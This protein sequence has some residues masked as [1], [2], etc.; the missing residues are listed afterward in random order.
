V[1]RPESEQIDQASFECSHS[2]ADV[3]RFRG[4]RRHPAIVPRELEGRCDPAAGSSC[5][6]LRKRER[7]D[8]PRR[9]ALAREVEPGALRRRSPAGKIRRECH[10]A[11]DRNEG[12]LPRT[13][14]RKSGGAAWEEG[15]QRMILLVATSRGC[16]K[17]QH[18]R[19][20]QGRRIHA[21]PARDAIECWVFGRLFEA[22]T[23]PSRTAGR[24][25][26]AQDE[27]LGRLNQ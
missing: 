27:V 12:P 7:A 8:Q 3:G 4:I 1:G 9:T 18:R 6:E 15:R 13:H 2:P 19:P 5:F 24:F 23:P 25:S 20:E 16:S 11:R 26:L 17:A 14:A 10:L 22:A 21:S